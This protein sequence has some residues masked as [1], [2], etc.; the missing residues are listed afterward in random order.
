[1]IIDY[2]DYVDIYTPKG[3]RERKGIGN[4]YCNAIKCLVCGWYL[5]SRNRHDAVYC[6]CENKAMVDGGSW[7]VRYGA[8]DMNKVGVKTIY[9]DDV[10]IDEE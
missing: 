5:R 1:M 4:I 9:F 7:Y 10:E 6:K 8:K 2:H 3:E